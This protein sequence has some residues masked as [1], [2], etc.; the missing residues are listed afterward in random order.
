MRKVLLM[1]IFYG[2]L[3]YGASVLGQEPIPRFRIKGVI[4][5][6]RT[7]K[8]V[9]KMPITVMPF[10]RTVEAD[11]KGSFLFNMPAG[12]YT[13]V[14]DYY[15]F[16]K[17]EVK[18]NLQSDTTLF[19]EM[20]APFTSN[21]LDE[22][23]T[24][25]S[26]PATEIPAGIT[27]MDARYFK[28]LPTIAGE[29]DLL[30]A[31]SF[32]TGVSSSSEGAADMQ[33]RGGV[34][35][36]N[37]YLLDGIP[38]YSTE[39]FFGLVSAFNP[40]IIKSAT[41]YKSDFPTEYGGKV[42]AVLS[43]LTEDADLNK[44]K[45]EAEIG[46][47]SS[48]ASLNIPLVK[49]KLAL[50]V[51]ER[52]SNYSLVNLFSPLLTA[53]SGI[54][55]SLLFGDTNANLLWKL[56]DKDKLKLS[57]FGNSDGIEVMDRGSNGDSKF[58]NTNSQKNGGLNWTRSLPGKGE[59]SLF[60][61][62]DLYKFDY[63][64]STE[65]KSSNSKLIYQYLSGIQ[66]TGVEDK[67]SIQLSDSLKLKVGGSIKQFGFLPLRVNL[68]DTS[69]TAVAVSTLLRQWEG[70]MF[71][72]TVYQLAKQHQLTTGLR[73]STMGN[74][75]QLFTNWEPRL[76][77]HGI[78]PNNYSISASVGRMSQPI[79]R[80]ANPGLGF[81]YE[82]FFPSNAG[83]LPETSWNFSMGAA[84]DLRWNKKVLTFKFDAW[85]KSF[86]NIVEFKEGYDVMM[87]VRYAGSRISKHP[88]EILTMGKGKAYGI[89][90][91][92]EY[93]MK[94]WAFTANYTLMKAENQFAEL[95]GGMPF[96]APTDMRHTISLSSELKL[97][98]TWS[99]MATW[100]YHTG[101][102]VTV[103]T[104][105]FV[106]PL[107]FDGKGYEYGGNFQRIEGQRNNYRTKD[108]HKLDLS[109]AHKYKAFRKYDGTFTVG[110]YNAYNRANPF[111]YFVDGEYN[112]AD[113]SYTPVLKMASLFPIMP[114]FN[115]LVRF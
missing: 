64:I 70:V 89:D 10:N 36:Q 47:L 61:Y 2:V 72:E 97:S 84:K 32:T 86:Q 15:P 105:I 9:K 16:D 74:E 50:M 29:R 56:S 68:N 95:N 12:N 20:H 66:S 73:L 44:R 115:W 59:N 76:G 69:T 26:K 41:L 33:V 40:T 45:G 111:V 92:S 67:L 107:D 113:R 35:G 102:A 79:H 58:W 104:T 13:L 93:T 103:P 62:T 88:T 81:P 49:D 7:K 1:I 17:M 90:I 57:Y 24:V 4:I 30:K 98:D 39:H 3:F 28:A 46:L 85:Y 5:D 78:F 14:L 6:G 21:L 27:Q 65:E 108:F 8:G 51:S 63:G 114:S 100:Q 82:L 71:A 55:L 48:K 23:E 94:H 80:V 54:S 25:A 110:L 53:K 38:L 109:F 91:S 106:E 83:L 77:Y 11:S 101:R 60:V 37:L 75:E 34:H 99:F 42:S 18:L 31:F 22:V 43:V 87:A 112:A 52:I 96:A 19:I